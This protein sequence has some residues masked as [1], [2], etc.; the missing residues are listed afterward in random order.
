M[1]SIGLFRP[2]VFQ[3]LTRPMPLG[4]RGLGVVL[5]MVFSV[6]PILVSRTRGTSLMILLITGDVGVLLILFGPISIL[7]TTLSGYRLCMVKY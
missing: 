2:V 6:V 7:S 1:V 5:F 3:L 4:E